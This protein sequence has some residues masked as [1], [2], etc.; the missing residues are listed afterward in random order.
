MPRVIPLAQVSF[1]D[2][3]HIEQACFQ[4][5]WSAATLNLYMN[6][7]ENLCLGIVSD[8]RLMGFAIFPVL[9]LR[10]SYCRLRLLKTAAG[11]A[12]PASCS[13]QPMFSLSS[14]V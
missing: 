6:N 7:P 3:E 5:P 8:E 14:R 11:R 10:P 9:K 4:P 12:S 2:V 1:A 13:V